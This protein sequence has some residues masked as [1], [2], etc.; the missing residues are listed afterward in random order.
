VAKEPSPWPAGV[1]KPAQRALAG[2][3]YD[4]LESLHG[5]SESRLADLHGMGPK[6]LTILREAL[7]KLG[8][9]LDP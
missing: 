4:S 6:A 8:L 3:G 1:A 5:A 9:S 2:A 7:A